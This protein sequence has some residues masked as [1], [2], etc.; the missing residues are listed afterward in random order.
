M[1]PYTILGVKRGASADEIKRAY[2][3]L[4][5]TYHPDVSNLPDASAL[6]SELNTAYD[7]ILNTPVYTRTKRP[8]SR[9][10][11]VSDLTTPRGVSRGG[12]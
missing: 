7:M 9:V 10:S 1:N 6:M 11:V 3:A 5:H 12:L 2:R 8:R 4:A